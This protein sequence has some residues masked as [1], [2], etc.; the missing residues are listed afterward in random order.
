MPALSTEI[1]AF[2]DSLRR[3]NASP[4]TIRNY[5]SDLRQFEAHI[6]P[7]APCRID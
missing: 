3:E 7:R 5:D 2:L 1:A 6:D 4:H